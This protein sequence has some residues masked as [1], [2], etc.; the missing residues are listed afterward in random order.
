[1]TTCASKKI[2]NGGNAITC[3]AAGKLNVI[4]RT[5]VCHVWN[6]GT[7]DT[8]QALKPYRPS[9]SDRL[10]ICSVCLVNKDAKENIEA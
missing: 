2:I 10:P 1:M 3:G 7:R 4:T 8:L 5:D 9:A 6:V